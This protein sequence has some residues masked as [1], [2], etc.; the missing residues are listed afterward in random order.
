MKTDT[1]IRIRP[2]EYHVAGHLQ[3]PASGRL[4]GWCW[5][6]D[7]PHDRQQVDI[8]C[9]DR[10]A[11]TLEASLFRP[12]IA[13]RG[14]GDGRYGFAVALPQAQD[15]PGGA[16]ISARAHATGQVFG[17]VDC[18]NG[19][20]APR[21]R[22]D[23]DAVS[24]DLSVLWRMLC[25]PLPVPRNA[26]GQAFARLGARLATPWNAP[27]MRDADVV[28]CDLLRR[29]P[30]FALTAIAAPEV[31]ILLGAATDFAATYSAIAA[32]APVLA[33]CSAEIVLVD[34]GT[35]PATALISA[36][37][38]NLAYVFTP[39][40]ATESA[41]GRFLLWIDAAAQPFSAAALRDVLG[42]LRDG[43]VLIGRRVIQA[44]RARGVAAKLAT[45]S[46]SAMARL[47]FDM[48][49]ERPRFAA[50]GGFDPAMADGD[51]LQYL[52]LVLRASQAGASIVRMAQPQPGRGAAIG[53]QLLDSEHASLSAVAFHHRWGRSGS[54]WQ[55]VLP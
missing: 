54:G 25:T 27:E 1:L 8:L 37:V 9:D 28:L 52:D 36:V 12:D 2:L 4:E 21:M 48:A 34:D 42:Y 24:R 38:C 7:R 13:R 47:P 17:R 49:M 45:S 15:G 50:L 22:P 39:G 53:V 41:R 20:Q 40:V 23:L 33:E 35:D 29:F 31:S 30:A 14:V 10:V 5:A 46:R 43:R 18:A 6:P 16:M 26:V 44:A 19:S 55:A 32:L 51:C 11:M 3:M